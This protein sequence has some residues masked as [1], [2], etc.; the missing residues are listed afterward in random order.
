[1]IAIAATVALLAYL[2]F[3]GFGV[4]YSLIRQQSPLVALLAAPGIGVSLV[5]VVIYPLNRIGIPI[6]ETALATAVALAVVATVGIF[7]ARPLRLRISHLG[8]FLIPV[9]AV[10]LIGL[11]QLQVGFDW[12]SFGNDDWA[13]YTL[14]AARFQSYGFSDTS[15]FAMAREGRDYSQYYWLMH[16]RDG[17]RP[18]ADMFIA[19]ASSVSTLNPHQV[20]M[21]VILALNG[22]L[23][24]GTGALAA[25]SASRGKRMIGAFIAC[26]LVAVSAL[27]IFGSLYQLVG[28]VGGLAIFVCV[29]ALLTLALRRSWESTTQTDGLRFGN[30]AALR[31]CSVPAVVTAALVVWYPEVLPWGVLGLGAAVGVMAVRRKLSRPVVRFLATLAVLVVVVTA[32][33][34]VLPN[35][36]RFLAMQ[37]SGGAFGSDD[38]GTLFPFFLLPS[39]LA[40]AFGVAAIAGVPS[41]WLDQLIVLG[42]V[43][44]LAI[45]GCAI[46]CLLRGSVTGGITVMMLLASGGFF[47]QHSGFA[48]YKM[49]M[50]LQPFAIASVAIVLTYVS[51]RVLA[52]VAVPLVLVALLNVNTARFYVNQSRPNAIGAFAETPGLSGASMASLRKIGDDARKAN[53]EIVIADA[54]FLTAKVAALE[55]KGAKVDVLS[56]SRRFTGLPD[57]P[58]YRQFAADFGGIRVDFEQAATPGDGALWLK[59]PMRSIFNGDKL[60]SETFEVGAMAAP[61]LVY[62]PSSVGPAYWDLPNRFRASFTQ[63]EGDPIVPGGVVQ[64][65]GRY[66]L[67]RIFGYQ[68]GDRIEVA[69]TATFLEQFGYRLAPVRIV[70]ASTSLLPFV[71]RGSGR[72]LSTP[73]NP[74]KIDDGFYVL[75]DFGR[76]GASRAGGAAGIAG[77][78]GTEYMADPRRISVY[79]REIAS[80]SAHEAAAAVS[81]S[82]IVGGSVATT[83]SF[84]YSGIFENGWLSQ[85]AEFYL[86][87]PADTR[88]ARFSLQL[89]RPSGLSV[90]NGEIDLRVDGRQVAVKCDAYECLANTLV[91]STAGSRD[92]LVSYSFNGVQRAIESWD[93]TLQLGTTEIVATK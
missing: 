44:L 50:Y 29:C 3:V 93:A 57:E 24:L 56:S 48:L 16:A 6:S 5:V 68:P 49:A 40:N 87:T 82:A 84:R 88:L 62:V 25:A 51:Y 52:V 92:I 42:G 91:G 81:P 89:I 34:G 58:K 55:L 4:S 11:P 23:I 14:G 53:S 45:A 32:V 8:L 59:S 22:T 71:G 66:S 19:W 74:M 67:F 72:L 77:L 64:A 21:P 36:L 63:S 86:S 60:R 17:V 38:Q 75:V 18:G 54:N 80:L 46:F 30:R 10:A 79:S 33:I 83:P 73:I 78:Y 7:R 9:G 76:E 28:Q 12:V 26:V 69:V 85:R 61:T 35:A 27:T 90:S 31:D 20:F 1:M 65:M 15:G 2:T 41:S 43:G 70:G 13:N 39:G 37:S 47:V